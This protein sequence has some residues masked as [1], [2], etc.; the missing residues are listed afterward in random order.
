MKHARTVEVVIIYDET[1]LHDL[2]IELRF[3]SSD[4]WRPAVW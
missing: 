2:R 3:L 1:G 4:Q